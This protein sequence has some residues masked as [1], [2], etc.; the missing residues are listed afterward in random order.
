MGN[1]YGLLPNFAWQLWWNFE[2]IP[3]KYIRSENN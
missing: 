1:K 3:K 2:M